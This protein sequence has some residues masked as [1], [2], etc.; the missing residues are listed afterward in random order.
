MA[1][2][3]GI[4]LIGNEILSGKVAD[5]NAAYLCRELRALGV[6]VR[7]ITVIPDEVDLIAP[8]C[9]EQSRGPRRGVHLGRRGPDPRRRDHGRRGAG[10]GVPGDPPPAPGRPARALLQGRA[11][12]GAAAA[13]PR[14]RRAP[15]WSPTS[16]SC[17]PPSSCATSTSCPACPRSSAR[18]STRSASGSG[19]RRSILIS[20][21]VDIGEGTLADHLNA[22]LARPS[23]ASARLVPGVL[24]SRVQGEGHARVQGPRPS[25]SGPWRSCSRRCRRGPW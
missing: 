17:S 2:T 11:Q 12:R 21:F 25:W 23:R 10:D 7:R 16:R 22:L 6:E 4:V 15:S 9:G 20:V 8:R 13:W 5:A 19:R 3:A 18:S 1:K 24:Q 14:Y